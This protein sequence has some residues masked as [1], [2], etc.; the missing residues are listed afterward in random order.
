M[1]LD[2]PTGRQ[3]DHPVASQFPARW[4]PRAFTDRS[5]A[6]SEVMSLLEAAR[7]APSASNHQPWR[8]VWARR[9][10]AAFDAIHSSLTGNNLIWAGKAAVLMVVASQDS[11]TNR[12]GEEVANRTAAFDT[13][14]AWMSLALQART[15]G[16][17]AHAMGGFDNARLASEVGLP[18][19]HTLHCVVAVGEQGSAE[20]LPDD[21]RAREKPS[22]RKPLDEIARHGH[23]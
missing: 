22:G 6:E 5:L 8:L 10:E 4:S 11:V 17:A 23:F 9:G 3:P 21:L 2:Q 18:A 15:M 20:A 16:L 7:W 13:G 12:A 1:S 14:A 19:G